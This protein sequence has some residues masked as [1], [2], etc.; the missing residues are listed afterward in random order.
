MPCF[1]HVYVEYTNWPLTHTHTHIPI[2]MY[3]ERI[4]R[5]YTNTAMKEKTTF[6]ISY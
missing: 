4:E 3:S 2:Y 6:T 1:R 5:K